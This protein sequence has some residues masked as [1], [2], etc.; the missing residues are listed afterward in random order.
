[1]FGEERTHVHDAYKSV[2]NFLPKGVQN[3]VLC[4]DQ[5]IYESATSWRNSRDIDVTFV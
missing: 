5:W 3:L 4:Y 1:M 2:G